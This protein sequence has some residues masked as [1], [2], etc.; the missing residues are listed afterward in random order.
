ME[1][2]RNLYIVGISTFQDTCN[3]TVRKSLKYL[4]LKM[5]TLHVFFKYLMHSN[6]RSQN[7]NEISSYTSKVLLH[8]LQTISSK[9][10]AISFQYQMFPQVGASEKKLSIYLSLRSK[11]FS[12]LG[13]A[14]IYLKQFPAN[15]VSAHTCV[16]FKMNQTNPRLSPFV[17]FFSEN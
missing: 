8:H 17:L 13:I 5:D 3:W 6:I 1:L 14:T 10:L 9:K 16:Y 2:L 7:F 4:I 11:K 12:D 15:L